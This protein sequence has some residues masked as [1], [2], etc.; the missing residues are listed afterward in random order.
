MF[1]IT[2]L[3]LLLVASAVMSLWSIALTFRLY[4]NVVAKDP[5]RLLQIVGISW[6]F[7]I[8]VLLPSVLDIALTG[9]LL[10]SLT[11]TMRQVYAVHTRR[12]IS[13]LANVV[14][15]SALP[16][17]LC[18]ICVSVFYVQF[19]TGRQKGFQLWMPIFQQ[20]IG[21]LYVLS[22][23]YMINAQPFRSDEHPAT[24]MSTLTVPAE[25]MY[26]FT[27]EARGREARCNDTGAECGTARTVE[28][29]V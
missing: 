17:T 8:S 19:T 16:P 18:A 4:I 15:Q 9:I 24:F 29:A 21:K 22:L 26:T 11:R 7:L 23:F 25:A 10:Y 13:R 28:V 14:W 3:V 12:R 5:L 1:I 2:P 6:N 20:M 27:G